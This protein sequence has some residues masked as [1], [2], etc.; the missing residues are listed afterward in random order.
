ME[1]ASVIIVGGGPGGSTCAR[2]LSKHGI[3]V[4]ILDK[5]QFPRTKLCAGWIT[6]RV[7]E[8]LE[9]EPADYPGSLLAYRWIRFYFKGIPLPV[10]TYQYSIRRFEFDNFLLR[11]A[12]VP[13]RRHRVKNIRTEN[14]KY[15]IDDAYK[16]KYLVGA[17]G[18]HCPV[19]KTLFP[20]IHPRDPEL[21]IATAEE[22]FAW[23]WKD[24]GCRL[25]FFDRGLPGYAWYVPKQNGYLNVGIG[26]KL[27]SL[28]RRGETIN[29]HWKG[30][31]GMLSRKGLTAGR[32]F[33]PKGH[34]YYLR[35]KTENTRLENAFIIGDAAGLATSDMGEG[36]GPA[37]ES[38]ILA[39]RSIIYA[40]PFS[41]G[42]VTR[43]SAPQILTG[44]FA[45]GSL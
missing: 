18:T 35:G 19:Y 36:I 22:E 30:F 24:S 12:G 1:E 38:G 14:E 21:C 13:V 8:D 25:W 4:L 27:A 11:R 33:S 15:I 41:L 26:G 16:C 28:K 40:A 17:G 20:E 39:A 45:G 42:S 5:Q 10:P 43:W 7:L 9:L 37:V 32:R 29:T 2:E 31:T 3:D 23:Q 6:P 34:I 44:R